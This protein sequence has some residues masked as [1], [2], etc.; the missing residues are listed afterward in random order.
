MAVASGSGMTKPL[1][2]EKKWC[3]YVSRSSHRKAQAVKG[4]T[5]PG[6]SANGQK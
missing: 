6:L 2:G 3:V 1:K 4:E 5:G